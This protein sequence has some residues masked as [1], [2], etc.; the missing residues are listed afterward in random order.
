MLLST[1][2]RL[3]PTSPSLSSILYARW[4]LLAGVGVE[5]VVV[6]F[7]F[8]GHQEGDIALLMAGLGVRAWREG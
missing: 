6:L 3:A 7:L 1:R 2:P 5:R 4:L 8:P